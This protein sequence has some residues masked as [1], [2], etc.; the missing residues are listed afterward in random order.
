[1][2]NMLEKV[3][4]LVEFRASFAPHLAPSQPVPFKYWR[5]CRLLKARDRIGLVVFM[6]VAVVD[7]A[8]PQ[9]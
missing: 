6:V 3:I 1:M 9:L 4:F 7:E 5:V 8:N 2:V